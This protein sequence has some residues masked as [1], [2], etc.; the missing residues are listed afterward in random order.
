MTANRDKHIWGLAQ[1]KDVPIVDDSNLPSVQQVKTNHPGPNPDESWPFLSGEEAISKMKVPEHC[2]VNLFASEEQFPELI[3]P[4]QMAWDTKGRLWVAVWRNYPERTPTSK[5][6]DSILI[7]EDTKGTGHADKVTHLHR[8]PELPHRLPVLQG[9]HPPDAGPGPLVRPRQ[10]RRRPCRHHGAR[11]DGDGFSRFPPH[12]QLDGA[13]SGR[14]H[15]PQRRRLPPHAR[16]K[17][18]KARC[19]TKTPASIASSRITGKFERYAPYGFANPHGRVFDYWGNDLIT[20]ATGNNTYFGPAISGH[21]DYPAKH[22]SIKQF[23]ER[24]SRPCPGT[25]HDDQQALSRRVLGELPQLQRDRLPGHLPRE[26]YRR[27][28]GADRHHDT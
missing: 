5:V 7:F 26:G 12:H 20:D 23:W 8:Q 28:L 6:G 27:R 3:K 21:I 16:W 25:G 14:R 2:K 1:G 13:R 24:P 11:G 4:L 22:P 9:R 18:T 10:P 17:P 19:G 15:L